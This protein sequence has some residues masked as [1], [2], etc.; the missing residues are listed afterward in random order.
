[1]NPT[2][3]SQLRSALNARR[4]QEADRLLRSRLSCL[5]DAEEARAL[6]DLISWANLMVRVARAHDGAQLAGI[7]RSRRYL[8][9]P[10]PVSPTRDISG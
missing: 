2:F 6:R 5:R 9:T 1:M 3:Q 4:Y 7:E 10:P 8:G